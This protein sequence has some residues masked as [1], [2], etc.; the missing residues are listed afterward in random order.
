MRL[1]CT[2]LLLTYILLLCGC[3]LVKEPMPEV[4]LT[5]VPVCYNY[6]CLDVEYVSISQQRWASVKALFSAPASAFAERLA[7]R[8]AIALLEREVALYT[9]VYNDQPKNNA[10]PNVHGRQDCIDEAH[11][12]LHFLLLLQQAKLLSFH[13]VDGRVV[14]FVTLIDQHYAVR[15]S[16]LADNKR[17]VVDSWHRGNGEPA[18]IQL[19]SRWLLKQPFSKKNNPR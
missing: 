4:A 13:R 11:N 16:S 7:I 15:I 10:Q 18:Y 8:Q 17:Y 5:A 14:R 12:T 1:Q 9:P 19:Y 2:P 3:G 6:G